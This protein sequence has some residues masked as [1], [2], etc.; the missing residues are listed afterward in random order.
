MFIGRAP[1]EDAGEVPLVI[2]D[3][4]DDTVYETK[5]AQIADII[6]W[7]W[8]DLVIVVKDEGDPEAVLN[9]M[10]TVT[11]LELKD[12]I[13][14]LIRDGDSTFAYSPGTPTGS[15]MLPLM[16]ES[17]HKMEK[18]ITMSTGPLP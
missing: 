16:Q 14:D 1:F 11:S 8:R 6:A 15:L 3:S 17:T 7:L 12:A 9:I 13:A 5:Y 4:K 18:T 10:T 2:K